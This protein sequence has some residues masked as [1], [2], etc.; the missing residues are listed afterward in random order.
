M[1]L[2]KFGQALHTLQIDMGEDFAFALKKKI[3]DHFEEDVEHNGSFKD[4]VFQVI[5]D[6]MTD[7][8]AKIKSRKIIIHPIAPKKTKK[9]NGWHFF[10]PIEGDKEEH[11]QLGQQLKMRA[12]SEA[13]KFMSDE[14]KEPFNKMADDHNA[15]QP[16]YCAEKEPKQPKQP[17]EPKEPKQ[18]KQPKQPKEPKEP[19]EKAKPAKAKAK[20]AKVS[21]LAKDDESHADNDDDDDV[22][23]DKD[24]A[25]ESDNDSD[26]NTKPKSK[27][28]KTK[29]E[30]QPKVT[31]QTKPTAT[32]KKAKPTKTTDDDDDKKSDSDESEVPED[33]PND[34]EIGGLSD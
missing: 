7:A 19:K 28:K 1:S 5:D 31:K 3:D 13:W 23:S 15:V 24:S 18:P 11:K 17:K 8:T 27:P 12:C 34:Q 16:E 22:Q 6:V 14:Q 25:I 10:W 32:K 29:V 30:K 26:S 9:L 21:K 2:N 20:P 33:I 4:Q